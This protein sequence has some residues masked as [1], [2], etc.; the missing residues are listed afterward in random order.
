[1][2]N[3]FH[4]EILE[5]VVKVS[6]EP[7]RDAFLNHYLG[8]DHVQYPIRTPALRAIAK[9]WMRSHRDLE[10]KEIMEMVGSFIKAPSSTEKILAGILLG[11]TTKAQRDFNPEIFE[12]WL[13]HLVGWA[14][15]DA[16][17]TGDFTITQLP[18]DWPK[19]KKILTRFSKDQN[20][21]KRRASLVLLCS[22]LS[23]VKDDRL[24]GH[25]LHNIDRLMKEKEVLITKAV[26]WLLRRMIKYYRNEVTDY[27][28]ENKES[29]PKI[30]VREVSIKLETGR[31]NG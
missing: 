3:R 6:G 1:M 10:A 8:N 24:A 4:R 15:V 28:N 5:Q 12:S 14:E 31:K 27:L 2:K 18:K 29:L 26:S 23:R 11:Y 20:I 16:V 30:A 22:P 7:K 21:H 9:D 25:A 17:C 19:W 13:D